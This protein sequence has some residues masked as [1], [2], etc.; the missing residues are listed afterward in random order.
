MRSSLLA[1]Y[2]AEVR[3]DPPPQPG[4]RYEREDGVVRAC[5]R[6]WWMWA[7]NLEPADAEQVVSRETQRFK[8]LGEAVEWKVYGHDPC[9]QL[10]KYLA[11]HG[12]VPDEPE[13]LMV[14]D[15]VDWRSPFSPPDGVQIRRVAEA[16]GL[17]DLIAVTSEAFGDVDTGMYDEL[18]A[19]CLADDPSVFCYVA[20]VAD[21]AVAAGRMESTA[22]STFASLWGGCTIP[23]F[24]RRGIF[25]ALVSVRVEDARKRGHS[26]IAVDAAQSRPIL[27]QLGFQVMTTVT[28]WRLAAA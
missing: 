7:H 22:G 25:R 6:T 9:T 3:F 28:G 24:R 26:Y 18:E 14:L 1:L 20:Y 15:L 4:V 2:D 13:T 17:H 23:D 11:A 12:F 16:Q 19:T 27:E 5:G 8:E 21:K 10:P